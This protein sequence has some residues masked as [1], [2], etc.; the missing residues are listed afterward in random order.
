MD[1]PNDM[2]D[3]VILALGTF[4]AVKFLLD[5]LTCMCTRKSKKYDLL[6]SEIAELKAQN[7]RIIAGL[8]SEAEYVSETQE[9]VQEERAQEER[10]QEERAQEEQ[11]QEQVQAEQVQTTQAY[12]EGNP[13]IER[14]TAQT[15]TIVDELSHSA[16]VEEKHKR[17][18]QRLTPG[19]LVY[20]SYKK[21]TFPATFTVKTDAPHGYVFE[22]GTETFLTPSQ[23]S[24]KRKHAL[25]PEVSS[26]N[27]WD[28]VYVITGR[29]EKNK[30]IKKSLNELIA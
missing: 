4:T 25:N 15:N 24:F 6:L 22:A 19:Q 3:K 5:A 14:P 8:Y 17:L 28:T 29:T 20:V 21:T 30:D 13:I 2:P 1:F 12:T 23:F 10:A 9:E 7:E 26:D 11:E 27:G 16:K 18:L